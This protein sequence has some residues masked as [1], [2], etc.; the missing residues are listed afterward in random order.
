MRMNVPPNVICCHIPP[1]VQH[2]SSCL[3]RAPGCYVAAGSICPGL[4]A[5]LCMWWARSVG[6]VPVSVAGGQ[7]PLGDPIWGADE[8]PRLSPLRGWLIWWGG[9]VTGSDLFHTYSTCLTH[10]HTHPHTHTHTVRHTH[11]RVIQKSNCGLGETHM[12]ESREQSQSPQEWN[13]K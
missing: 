2:V 12:D 3:R 10:T 1:P 4:G 9:A 11:T 6:W 13:F 7:A 8:W 5:I